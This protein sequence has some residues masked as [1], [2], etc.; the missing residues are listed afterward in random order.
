VFL[1]KL[2]SLGFSDAYVSWFRSYLTNRRSRV[3]VYGTLS[4]PFQITS[5]VLQGSVLGPFL[6]NLFI[7]DLCSSV[8]YCKILIFADD[9]NIF[10]VI[11]SQHDCLLFQSD[12]NS[13]N[14][15]CIAN[16]MRLSTAKTRV[17]SYTRKKKFFSYNYQLCRA[18]IHAPAVLRTSV[19]SLISNYIS[20]IMSIMYFLNVFSF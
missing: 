15:W 9:I 17:A 10:R 3:R 8:Q 19:S 6:F 12:I 13:V 18:T 4:Q 1:H 7:N 11:N 20:T 5:G 2:G 14:D 16:S